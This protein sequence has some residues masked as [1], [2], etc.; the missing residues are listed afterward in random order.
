MP[1]NWEGYALSFSIYIHHY[2]LPACAGKALLCQLFQNQ[3]K[4]VPDSKQ[5]DLK[6]TSLF[7][8]FWDTQSWEAEC[9]GKHR[10]LREKGFGERVNLMAV[11]LLPRKV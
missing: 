5:A 1:Q 8:L 10:D 4:S 3:Q 2:L 6:I 11:F 7:A 9:M